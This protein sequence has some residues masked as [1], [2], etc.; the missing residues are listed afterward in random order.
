MPGFDWASVQLETISLWN[1]PTYEHS[2]DY[3]GGISVGGKAPRTGREPKYEDL[4]RDAAADLFDSS[5]SAL[6][7]LEK[8]YSST[9]HRKLTVKNFRTVIPDVQFKKTRSSSEL[10]TLPQVFEF[11]NGF[12]WLLVY[13]PS[14]IRDS[15]MQMLWRQGAAEDWLW[16]SV[17]EIW[18]AHCD[19]FPEED[20]K[21]ALGS[22]VESIS[23]FFRIVASAPSL[24][25]IE[26]DERCVKSIE[27]VIE[28]AFETLV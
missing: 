25:N 21:N 17:R 8:A 28:K 2:L 1:P 20:V 15:N 16:K 10:T 12:L 13:H 23:Y 24:E 11:L 7:A 22:L 14:A 4:L 27:E 26:D 19:E 3:V 18:I 6:D 5:Q 9:S